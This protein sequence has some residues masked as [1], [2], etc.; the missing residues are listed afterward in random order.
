MWAYLRW[1]STLCFYDLGIRMVSSNTLKQLCNAW[2]YP[3]PHPQ[4]KGGNFF[5]RPA[6]LRILS[7]PPPPGIS[8]NHDQG[9][10]GGSGEGPGGPI[11]LTFRPKW[12]PKGG[13]KFFEPP[14]GLDH[15]PSPRPLSEGLDTPLG[16]SINTDGRRNTSA[17]VLTEVD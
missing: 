9:V 6:F 7:Y 2:K 5:F 14:Q 10:S 15:R 12:G 17:T 1:L 16:V 11:P 13:K 3:F 4:T 8:H